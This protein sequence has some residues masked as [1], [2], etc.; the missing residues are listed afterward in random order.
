MN[1]RKIIGIQVQSDGSYGPCF[2]FF[3]KDIMGIEMWKPV[4]NYNVPFFYTRT[5]NFSVLTTMG[6]CEGAFPGFRFLDSSNYVNIENIDRLVTGRYGAVAY[7]KNSEMHTGVNKKNLELWNNIIE[8]IKQLQQDDRDVLGTAI[9][10]TGELSVGEFFPAREIFYIDMWEPKANYYV[11]RFY[12]NKGMYTVGLTYRS[13]A[14]ALPY[15]FPAHNGNL[16]NPTWIDHIDEQF[17][18]STVI[19]K[20]SDYRADVARKKVK[21]LKSLL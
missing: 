18:G 20:D 9:L 12:T 8:E 15:L 19:F 1:D 6:A 10:K 14:E 2:S 4:N 11:P 5:G 21:I 17:Y 13:C 16:V 7:F 3:E